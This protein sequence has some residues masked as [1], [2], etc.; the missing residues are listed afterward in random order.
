ME[1]RRDVFRKIQSEF[2][3]LTKEPD[4]ERMVEQSIQLILSTN[5]AKVR[6]H[7]VECAV[8]IH[9]ELVQRDKTS[10][11][12][13]FASR[14]TQLDWMD[15]GLVRFWRTILVEDLLAAQMIQEAYANLQK[16]LSIELVPVHIAF[17]GWYSY[18]NSDVEGAIRCLEECVSLHDAFVRVGELLKKYNI[19]PLLSTYV[20]GRGLSPWVEEIF[21]QYEEYRSRIATSLIGMLESGLKDPRLMYVRGGR[22]W[23]RVMRFIKKI[24][25]WFETED[26]QIANQAQILIDEFQRQGIDLN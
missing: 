16:L 21:D 11:A 23:N 24:I 3:E 7:A 20:L 22:G 8:M 5:D 12:R 9:H 18:L 1:T 25:H 15:S 4:E 10:L 6:Q 14:L 26:P 19:N 17:L 13:D 2:L